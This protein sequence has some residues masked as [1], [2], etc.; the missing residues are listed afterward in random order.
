MFCPKC[1]RGAGDDDAFCR[2]CGSSLS[3][4]TVI[5][6]GPARQADAA[7]P[8]PSGEAPLK[9][10]GEATASLILGLFSFLPVVGLIA[11]IFGHM[12]KASIRRSGD[13]LLGDGMASFGLFL[14][15]LGLGGWVAYG[16][17]LVALPNLPST[18]RA[19]NRE[20]V[21][22][23]LRTIN[24]AEVTYASTY[25]NGYSPS[26]ADLGPPELG[27]RS[28]NAEGAIKWE[29]AQ[30]AGLIDSVL[31]SGT[32]IAYRFTYS[33]GPKKHGRIDTYTVHADPLSPD[34]TW[35]YFTDE[36]G[37]IREQLGNEANSESMPLDSS[38][39]PSN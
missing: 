10:S 8:D 25:D 33:S 38:S 36:S 20:A 14:G 31:S 13:R 24:T 3:G 19:E 11:I 5:S 32:K 23:S 7:G 28:P 26:L 39:L 30:A 35:H 17:W 2:Q 34:E 21:V 15:Y 29:N 6:T 1:G 9:R 22:G 4:E 12:A 37:V 27:D 18:I 16:L